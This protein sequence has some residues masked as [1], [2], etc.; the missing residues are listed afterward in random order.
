MAIGANLNPAIWLEN[1]VFAEL[2][3]SAARGTARKI[4]Q[5]QEQIPPDDLPEMHHSGC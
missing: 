5:H 1:R 3:R 2:A 4:E